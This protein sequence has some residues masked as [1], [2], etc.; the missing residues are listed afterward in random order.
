LSSF[1]L[2]LILRVITSPNSAFSQIRDNPEKYFAQ[3]IG[4]LIFSS[5]LGILVVLP[6]VM[7]PL[8]DAYFEGIGSTVSIKNDL[9]SG[10]TDVI[11]YV[12]LS[13]LNGFISAVLFYFIGKKLGGDTNWK[14]VFSVIFHTNAVA[15][16]MII[17]LSILIFFM[18]DSLT[19]IEPT[20]LL[21]PDVNDEEIWSTLVPFLGYLALVV[22][23][24]IGFFVWLIVILVKAVKIVHGFETGKA[25]G[26]VVLVMIITTIVTIP[27]SN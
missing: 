24:G 18:W 20:Y 19:L 2:G 6:F 27:L 26:L 22:I 7:M 1:D 9:P 10:G 4:L 13:I 5:V 21:A 15:I 3:S 23:V 25:F 16:P 14:K 11:W 17:I 12:G 8:D